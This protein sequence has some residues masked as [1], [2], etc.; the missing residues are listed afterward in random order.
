MTAVVIGARNRG[1]GGEDIVAAFDDASRQSTGVQTN[2]SS[3]RIESEV[4][5][6]PMRKARLA[7]WNALG[8]PSSSTVA[9]LFF[10]L[11]LTLI[12]ISCVAFVVE[13]IP[14]YC[15]GRYANIFDAIENVCV[16]AFTFEYMARLIVVPTSVDNEGMLSCADKTGAKPEILTRLRFFFKV[17]NLVDFVAI[18]PFYIIIMVEASGSNAGGL[19]GTSFLRVV[20]LA[21]VFRL[22]KL[23]KYSDG[24][25]L[26]TA[27]LIRSWRALGMLSFFMLI[28]VILFSS[29]MYFVEKGRF[30]YCTDEAA[31]SIPPLCLQQ[32]VWDSIPTEALQTPLHECHLLATQEYLGSDFPL[33]CCDG[34]GFYVWP[35]VD[36]DANGCLDRSA[37]DSIFSTAWWCVVTMTTVGYGDTY[38]NSTEG[39]VLACLTML[40]GILILALPITVIGSNFNIEYEK[41]EAEARMRLQLELVPDEASDP[42]AHPTAATANAG[43]HKALL[44]AVEKLLSE[45]RDLILKRA[46]DMIAQH[47]REIAKEVVSQAHSSSAQPNAPR[48]IAPS[49]NPRIPA[50]QP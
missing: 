12:L 25:W 27:T 4:D 3:S 40:S 49:S 30:F 42:Q 47:V 41:S 32:D 43:S 28:S 14:S 48:S 21:R 31:K 18:F 23:S 26:L 10:V 29:I 50:R 20:R 17:F 24:M 46:E 6:T 5:D 7:V 44:A 36:F 22:F 8:D 37:Y 39:K 13:T 45:Q 15:C 35:P 19:Q 34:E 11:I 2:M 9:Y 1:R 16:V 38:P 33:K